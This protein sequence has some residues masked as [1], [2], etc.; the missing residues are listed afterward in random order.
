ME[1]SDTVDIHVCMTCQHEQASA[2]EERPGAQF[3]RQLEQALNEGAYDVPVRLHAAGCFAV[4]K[5][6][7]TIAVTAPNKWTY[8][9]G[10]LSAEN[11]IEDVLEY[12]RVYAASEHGTMPLKDRPAIIRRGTIARLPPHLHESP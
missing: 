6:P 5:R 11:D 7:C 12:A 10:D 3:H 1:L 4:C 2:D 9:I 8:I